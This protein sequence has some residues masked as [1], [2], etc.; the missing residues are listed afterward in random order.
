MPAFH[1]FPPR[2]QRGVVT[3]ELGLTLLMFLTCIFAFIELARA[4]YLWNTVQEITRQAARMAAVT[5]FSDAG[6]L[7]TV[8]EGALFRSAPGRL[9]GGGLISDAYVRIDYLALD[10]A[11]QLQPVAAL[12]GCPK[13]NLINCLNDPNGTSCI[14]F[15]RVRLCQPGLAACNVPYVPMLA[16]LTPLFTRAD[17]VLPDGKTEVRAETLGYRPGAPDCP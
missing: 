12:P 11:G 7:A 2:Q 17:F 8:R 15:V 4:L 14:R 10:N 5:D 9:F 3:V 1:P 16:L 6:A 13:Q